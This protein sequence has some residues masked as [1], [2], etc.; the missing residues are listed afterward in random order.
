MVD[1]DEAGPASGVHLWSLLVIG[2]SIAFIT[3]LALFTGRLDSVWPLYL[4][5]IVVAG[6]AFGPAA[7]VLASALC[8]AT[9]A[10][11][12]S[13]TVPYT[14]STP[15]LITGFVVF[16]LT[17]FL[18]GRMAQRQRMHTIEL[19][20]ASITDELTGLYK[21]EHFLMRLEEEIRRCDRYGVPIGL[22]V[23]RATGYDHFVEKF[24]R[25][26]AELMLEHMADILRISVRDT[27]VISRC[28]AIDFAVI[29]PFSTPNDFAQVAERVERALDHSEYEGDVL[30]PSTVTTFAV[31]GAS[32]PVDAQDRDE[33][34]D[35][36]L[37]RL[38]EAAG[39]Y[40]E[41][42][43]ATVEGAGAASAVMAPVRREV[44]P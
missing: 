29:L 28:G 36:A 22:V 11:L 38:L 25:Y 33:L 6:I 39:A 17:G 15:A 14:G 42:D 23:C 30:E 20:H 1:R 18:V 7:A 10:V 5:P 24:G 44:L 27:D 13:G 43:A 34:L 9:L 32:Y 16:T 40:G 41:A 35:V 31:A 21:P 26:K 8:V 12:G 19:E 3:L 2:A 4:A 37:R